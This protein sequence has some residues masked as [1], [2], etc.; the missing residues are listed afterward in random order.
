[1]LM[2]DYSGPR[3]HNQASNRATSQRASERIGFRAASGGLF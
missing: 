2:T 1:M 3:A